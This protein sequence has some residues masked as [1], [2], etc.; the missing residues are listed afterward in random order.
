MNSV[1]NL[2]IEDL[3]FDEIDMVDG[4]LGIGAVS[5]DAVFGAGVAFVIA[6][7]VM[8]GGLSLGFAFVGGALVG[9]GV[10]PSGK[11]AHVQPV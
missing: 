2:N 5:S 9:W 6:S 7:A 11:N 8:T 1:T 3:S 4:A 10:A